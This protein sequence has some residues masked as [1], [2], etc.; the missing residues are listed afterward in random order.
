MSMYGYDISFYDYG[1]N[2]PSV[3]T[4]SIFGNPIIDYDDHLYAAR[5]RPPARQRDIP[6]NTP[7]VLRHDGSSPLPLGMDWS[8]PPRVWEGR[9]SV[10]PHDS[11][12]KWSYCV[13]VPSW[14]I[15]PSASGSETVFFKVQVGIQS[16]EGITSTREVLR[17]F[18]DFLNLYSELRK[19]FPKKHLPS[20]PPRRLIKM[21]SKTLLEERRG[22]LEGWVEKLLS[23][24]DVSRT[25]LVAIF[26]ELEAA[27]RQ[28]FSELNKNESAANSA[29]SDPFPSNSQTSLLE[30]SSSITSDLDNPCPN[31]TSHVERESY[32]GMER[33]LE[34]LTRQ[35]ME[36]EL[37]LTIEQDA[38]ANA[39]SMKTTTMQQNEML[40]KELDDAKN[41]IEIL[42]KQQDVMELK[43][44]SDIKIL[45]EEV[46]SLRTSNT[47]LKQE[48]NQMLN[49][50]YSEQQR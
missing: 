48:L 49:S 41:Q 5:R 12:K 46:K 40:L 27:A 28:S 21:R 4:S 35:C 14:T 7:T 10:W 32:T 1:F 2:D 50:F 19:E 25:A 20:T 43:S 23:D 16:P 3:N 11:Q 26:L 34:E 31:E 24:I 44:K 38:R 42:K 8:L 17:R 22:A 36:L 15:I 9:N 18:N 30:S 39:E 13:T 47:E 37:R 33:D 45:V 29:P 6:A